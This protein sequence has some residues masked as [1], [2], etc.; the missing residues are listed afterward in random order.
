MTK[1]AKCFF[2]NGK[3]KTFTGSTNI[4]CENPSIGVEVCVTITGKACKYDIATYSCKEIVVSNTT[5]CSSLSNP[6]F[7]NNYACISIS[8]DVP[9]NVS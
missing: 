5:K 6:D 4:P 2:E 7:Y 8:S 1:T 9:N 3:C